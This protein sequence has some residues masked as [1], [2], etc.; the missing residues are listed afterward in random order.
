MDKQISFSDTVASNL[1]YYVYRLIDP[2]NGQTFYVGR[3]KGN[4]VFAH[5]RDKLVKEELDANDDDST[6]LQIIRD[7]HHSGFEVIHVIHRHGMDERTACE[8]E[9]ALIDAYPEASNLVG[10]LDS[11]K[12]G[13]MHAKQIIERYEAP[14]VVFRHDAILINVSRTWHDKPLLDAV[15]YAWKLDPRRAKGRLVLAVDRGLIIGVFVAEPKDWLEATPENFPGFPSV[16]DH[17]RPRWGFVG[18]EAPDEIARVYLRHRLPNEMR[19]PGA[20]AP[21]R[22]ADAKTHAAT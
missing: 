17:K 16:P 22:Y 2:R 10:G 21:I 7:I 20:Q 11:D 6:K 13:L 15:R 14:E 3:G 12:H 18:H 9:A 5:A 19:K 8:V 4:R 1:G